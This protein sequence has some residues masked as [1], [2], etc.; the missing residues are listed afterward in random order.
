M[1]A[2]HPAAPGRTRGPLS[3]TR[4][5]LVVEFVRNL[6]HST[7]VYSG[8]PFR[9]RKWQE[10]ILRELFGRMRVDDPKR[11]AYR[12]GFIGIPRKNGKSELCAAIALYGLIGDGIQGAQVYS[13]AAEKEQAAL[14]FNAAATMV[15]NDPELEA[16]IDILE[17]RK[18]MIDRATGSFYQA[19]SAEAY[20]KHGFNASLV[21]FDEL[22]ASPNRELWDVLRTSQGARREPLMLAITT[23]GFDRQSICY[24]LWDYARKVRDGVIDDPAFYQCLYEAADEDDWRDERVWRKANP[25]LGDFRD[26]DEMRAFANE[27]RHRPEQ[28]NTFR[29]L[30]LNQWTEQQTK[31][32]DMA[33]WAA[34]APVAVEDAAGLPTYAGLDLGYKNDFSALVGSTPLP[35]GRRLIRCRFWIPEGAMDRFRARPYATWQ[36]H[37]SLVVTPGDVVD[38]SRLEADIL[39]LADEWNLRELAYDE[40]FAEMLR[41]RLD[42]QWDPSARVMVP[43]RQ[44]FAL[45]AG[46]R[47]LEAAVLA[48]TYGHNGDPVLAWMAGNAVIDTGAKGDIRLAK[49]KA[50]DK[51]DGICAG[52]MAEQR[53]DLAIHVP[54]YEPQIISLR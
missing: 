35:D 6:T 26:I 4:G 18:R 29:R 24:E 20:S 23:A 27:A 44:G 47:A 9:L 5:G 43:M 17:T 1:S 15:R 46:L 39:A 14:V 41:Q 13:A 54:T 51:I 22:H 45:N 31:W 40:A 11:R 10:A 53:A 3:R 48:G 7:D 33:K 28:Q 42:Q 50:R 49:L 2:P 34:C 21:I 25:A 16:R 52:A 8:Q 30:Y 37:G 12:T 19:L 32:I 38:F 36:Q